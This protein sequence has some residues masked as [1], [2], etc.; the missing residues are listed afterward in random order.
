MDK[1][2]FLSLA[3]ENNFLKFKG[4]GPFKFS[5]NTQRPNATLISIDW[6]DF[7]PTLVFAGQSL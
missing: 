4:R 1:L 6:Y 5:K 7:S 3:A 2:H